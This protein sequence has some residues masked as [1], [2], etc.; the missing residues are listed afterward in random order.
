MYSDFS[1]TGG[2]V[3]FTPPLNSGNSSTTGGNTNSPLSS[4]GVFVERGPVYSGFSFVFNSGSFVP[5]AFGI[6]G[7]SVEII[8]STISSVIS[9]VFSLTI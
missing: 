9:P 6:K 2:S 7:V 5:L 4:T 8:L 3:E 1:S